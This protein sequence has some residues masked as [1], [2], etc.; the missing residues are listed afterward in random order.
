[1]AQSVINKCQLRALISDFLCLSAAGSG[2][3]DLDALLEDLCLMEKDMNSGSERES[4]L[5][6]PFASPNSPLSPNVKVCNFQSN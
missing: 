5:S 4:I 6:E 1:M 3:I 2:E